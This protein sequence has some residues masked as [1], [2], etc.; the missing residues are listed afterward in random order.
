MQPSVITHIFVTAFQR[1][2]GSA[3]VV[4]CLSGW[5]DVHCASER[6]QAAMGEWGICVLRVKKSGEAGT[7]L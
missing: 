6:V 4:L 5:A 3:R 2:H 1:R 7:Q